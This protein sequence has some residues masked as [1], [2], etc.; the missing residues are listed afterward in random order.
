MTKKNAEKHSLITIG[1]ARGLIALYNAM[2]KLGVMDAE[3]V[4]SEGICEEFA[5]EV[6]VPAVYGRV[7][8]GYTVSQKEWCALLLSIAAHSNGVNDET[9]RFIAQGFFNNTYF[10]CALPIAQEFYIKGMEDFNAYPYIHD[11]TK[12]D[13]HRMERWTRDGIVPHSRRKLFIELQTLCFYRQRIDNNS[14]SKKALRGKRYEWFASDLWARMTEGG[15][16]KI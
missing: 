4:G 7:I 12:F 9:Q 13:N 16:L 3:R 6:R 10:T 14:D 5:D 11:F 1:V 8:D 15:M 2:Y